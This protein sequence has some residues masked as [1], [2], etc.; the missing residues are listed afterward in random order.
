VIFPK[1]F[2]REKLREKKTWEIKRKKEIEEI[3]NKKGISENT[4]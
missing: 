1:V 4:K 3:E 2:C